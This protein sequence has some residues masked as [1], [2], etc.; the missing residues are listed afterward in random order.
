MNVKGHCGRAS[1]AA[2]SP[3]RSTFKESIVKKEYFHTALI[4]LAAFALVA[5]VQQKVMALPVV[6]GYLP[7]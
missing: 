4:A 1:E 6:G 3:P 2:G 5:F 7:K